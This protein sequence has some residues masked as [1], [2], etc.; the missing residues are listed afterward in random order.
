MSILSGFGETTLSTQLATACPLKLSIS[1][2][3][4][5]AIVKYTYSLEMCYPT[6]GNQGYANQQ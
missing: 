1:T 3:T 2:N 6:H 5:K 4:A